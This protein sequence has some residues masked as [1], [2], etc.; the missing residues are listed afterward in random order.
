M[1]L[2]NRK[3]TELDFDLHNYDIIDMATWE[4]LK[5]EAHA[6]Q[7][8]CFRVVGRSDAGRFQYVFFVGRHYWSEDDGE[9]NLAGRHVTVLVSE[10][11]GPDEPEILRNDESPISL[12]EILVL[13][14]ELVRRRWDGAA[15]RLVYDRNVTALQIAQDF[16]S[17]V[18][19]HRLV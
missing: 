1:T 19:R 6:P 16:L 2:L 13:G 7:T 18:V 15:G 12:R 8:W 11:R 9:L 4:S 17:E 14:N 10:Q 5:S 3:S